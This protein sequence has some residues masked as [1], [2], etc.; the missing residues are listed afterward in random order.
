MPLGAGWLGTEGQGWMGGGGAGCQAH[1]P[2]RLPALCECLPFA[3]RSPPSPSL[4]PLQVAVVLAVPAAPTE[5]RARVTTL[6]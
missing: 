1:W 2:G 6:P 4:P 5:P 3:L